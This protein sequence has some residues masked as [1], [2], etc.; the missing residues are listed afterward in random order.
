MSMVFFCL[1][2][3]IWIDNEIR[4]MD[5]IKCLYYE[6][7]LSCEDIMAE[8]QAMPNNS[9]RGLDVMNQIKTA[10]EN[11]CSCVIS[12]ADILAL[13]T[14]ISY[15]RVRV[16]MIAI[17]VMLMFSIIALLSAFAFHDNH[18]QKLLIG[19]V[20]LGVSVAMYASSLVA[21]VSN[22]YLSST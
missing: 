16:S 1:D 21:M 15:V 2:V 3:K 19:S 18:H 7:L 22:L 4:D 6:I 10:V 17:P 14:K 11:A 5:M 12:C 8:Q 9:I 20:G 13:A